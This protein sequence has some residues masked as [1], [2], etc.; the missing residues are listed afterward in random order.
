MEYVFTEAT[1]SNRDLYTQM[2]KVFH[3]LF[4]VD[5]LVAECNGNDVDKDGL[6]D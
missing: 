5:D 3:L 6:L 2:A 4:T 1:Y